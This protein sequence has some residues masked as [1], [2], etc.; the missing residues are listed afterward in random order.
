MVYELLANCIPPPIILKSLSKELSKRLDDELKHKLVFW[1]A[2]YEYQMQMGQ[3]PIY[4][5][6]AF[7]AKFMVLFKRYLMDLFG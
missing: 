1:A 6:E 4:Y 7:L 2:F 5:I 3:K